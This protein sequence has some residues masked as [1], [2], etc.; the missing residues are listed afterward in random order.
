MFV[1]G[2]LRRRFEEQGL[3][4]GDSRGFEPHLTIMKLSRASKL[5]AQVWTHYPYSCVV[6]RFIENS[7]IYQLA[8]NI[9]Q[10][11]PFTDIVKGLVSA[12]MFADMTTFI[13][14]N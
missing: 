8:D 12:F 7:V 9:S 14:Q 10:Y 2:L 6:K 1:A 5:R 3:L 11:E 4:Q 13:L